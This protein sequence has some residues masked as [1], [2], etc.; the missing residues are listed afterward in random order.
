MN[1]NNVNNNILSG[2]NEKEFGRGVSLYI[3]ID[4]YAKKYVD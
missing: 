4:L 3:I 2:E 1:K